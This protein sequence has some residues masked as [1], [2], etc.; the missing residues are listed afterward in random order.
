MEAVGKGAFRWPG[1][2]KPGGGRGE[3]GCHYHNGLTTSRIQSRSNVSEKWG[4]FVVRRERG[5]EGGTGGEGGWPRHAKP[6]R[7]P[8]DEWVWKGEGP[9]E[10]EATRSGFCSRPVSPGWGKG[11]GGWV[12]PAGPPTPI[13]PLFVPPRGEVYPTLV[14]CVPVG[15]PHLPLWSSEVCTRYSRLLDRILAVPSAPHF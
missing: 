1:H 7:W 4:G 9:Q 11:I 13:G 10:G 5:G 14:G 12:C 3:G 2:V 15:Q 6:G 8:D